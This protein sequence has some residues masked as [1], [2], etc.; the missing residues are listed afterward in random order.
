MRV[1]YNP[2]KSLFVERIF[3]PCFNLSCGWFPNH[4]IFEALL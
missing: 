1:N 2:F 3:K 4:C